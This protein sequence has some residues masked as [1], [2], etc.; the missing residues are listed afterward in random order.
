MDCDV[1]IA[2]AGLVG[3]SLALALGRAG[4]R[5]ALVE[6]APPRPPAAEWDSRIYAISPGS[7]ALLSRLGVWQTLDAARLAPVHEM[8]VW[9]DDGRSRLTFSALSAGLPELAVI[10]ENGRLQHALWRA[11][12]ACDN[13]AWLCPGRCAGVARTAGAVELTLADGGRAAA[14][15]LVGADGAQSWVR[16]Q[17]GI[18]AAVKP[19]GQSAVVANFACARSHDGVARQWFRRDGVLA[20]LPLP[21][22]RISIVWSVAEAR[23]A[24]LARL[25]AAELAL[26]VA[27]AGGHALGELQLI[28]PP[29]VFPL[30]LV[31][32]EALTAQRVA[33]V[34]DAAHVVHPLAGQGV[35]LG[36]QDAACLADILSGRGA[37]PDPGSAQLLR[38]YARA[39]KED[40]ISMQFTT[41]GL[42]RLFNNDSALLAL[43]RNLGLVL[44]DAL[45]P[46]KGALVRHAVAV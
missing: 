15:L 33:L 29:A 43:A 32:V 1:I 25:P 28:T 30:R 21:G 44:T 12:E 19:Y 11:L 7:V 31:R 20:W 16:E 35:N 36:L 38:R 22:R 18:A 42:Q 5:V 45:G 17:A 23:A 46:L 3:S 41:D 24:E 34:G 9:G 27:D 26:A 37:D 39:R 2:G 4:L 6:P 10:A 8:H 40:I 14:A 13:V